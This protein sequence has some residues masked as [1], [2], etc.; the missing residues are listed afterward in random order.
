LY[1]SVP[2]EFR[3]LGALCDQIERFS[4]KIPPEFAW[5]DK[6]YAVRDSTLIDRLKT[7]V[8]E[9]IRRGDI[10][11]LELAAPELI[12]WGEIDQFAFSFSPD[13]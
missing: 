1:L 5:V 3:K 4:K 9:M 13:T 11:N 8:I 10:Q 12:E 2:T 6:I 7:R